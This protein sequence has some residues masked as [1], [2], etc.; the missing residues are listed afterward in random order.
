MSGEHADSQAKNLNQSGCSQ[1]A[2]GTIL[3]SDKVVGAHRKW[4]VV[5]LAA[6]E[7]SPHL[8]AGQLA[9]RGLCMTSDCA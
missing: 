9:V 3:S 8:E 6:P 4:A 1:L 7:H 5:C 2:A